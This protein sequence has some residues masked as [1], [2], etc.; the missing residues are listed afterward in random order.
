M[1]AE[2]RVDRN[3]AEGREV[4]GELV[5]YDLETRGYLGGNRAAAVLWPL[6]VAGTGP[7]AMAA[8]LRAEFGIDEARAREDAEAF[9]ESLRERGLLVA[10]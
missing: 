1:S 6:L 5:I 4:G 8:A 10:D 2:L 7:E 3:R 9:V